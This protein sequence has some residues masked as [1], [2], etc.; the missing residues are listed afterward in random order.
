MNLAATAAGIA[1]LG[2]AS[3][4]PAQDNRSLTNSGIRSPQIRVGGGS[5]SPTGGDAPL[6]ERILLL[7]NSI[8]SLTQSLAVANSEAELFKRQASDLS[9]KL[10]T[11]GLSDAD[12][13]KLE[14]RLLAAVRDLRNAK[15]ENQELKDAIIRLTESVLT[16]LQ[17]TENVDPQTRSNMEI[18][19][20]SVNELLG[21]SPQA[22]DVIGTEPSLSDGLVIDIRDD[23]SL[24]VA[25]LGTRH[26]AKIGMPFQVWRGSQL[27]ANV[28]VVDV[29]DRISG[30]VIQNLE[31][32][33]NPVKAGDSL[34]V[35]ARQ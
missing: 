6:Q 20:R 25:N 19:L 8:R 29:R 17:A 32:Q 23:L 21:A 26:G 11:L 33:T 15:K 28:K 16:T 22:E 10:Q 13:S 27:V 2:L 1:V 12:E 24:V 7:E 30:A 34:R 18:Q 3:T 9:L 14:Q 4:A 5:V 35:D 31:T